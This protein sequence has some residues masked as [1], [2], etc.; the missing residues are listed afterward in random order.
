MAVESLIGT[1]EE[2][3]SRLSD[4][5]AQIP[6]GMFSYHRRQLVVDERLLNIEPILIRRF[7]KVFGEPLASSAGS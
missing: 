2:V 6:S 4:E 7:R 1:V 3:R 5:A